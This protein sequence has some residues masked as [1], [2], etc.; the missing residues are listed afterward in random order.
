MVVNLLAQIV[1]IRM[2]KKLFLQGNS[3]LIEKIIYNKPHSLKF[4][5]YNFSVEVLRKL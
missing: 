5:T 1:I 3:V 4:E 2:N